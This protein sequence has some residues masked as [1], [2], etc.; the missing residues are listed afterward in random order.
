MQNQPPRPKHQ[1]AGRQ[2]QNIRARF[3]AAENRWVIL[4]E[5][6]GALAPAAG[7]AACVPGALAYLAPIPFLALWANNHRDHTAGFEMP[8][9]VGVFRVRVL[10][11]APDGLKKPKSASRPAARA[12]GERQRWSMRGG[13]E[14]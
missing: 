7:R 10:R 4:L 13:A 12:A 11:G 1:K 14:N 3:A 6:F 9:N 2:L 5:F 8:M